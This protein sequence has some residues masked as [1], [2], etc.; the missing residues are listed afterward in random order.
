MKKTISNIQTHFSGNISESDLRDISV[1]IKAVYE[2]LYKIHGDSF[3]FN[4]MFIKIYN[5]D[6]CMKMVYKTSDSFTTITNVN[7]GFDRFTNDTTLI[8]KS[9]HFDETDGI[10]IIHL[11]SDDFKMDF[12]I[13][14]EFYH[15]VIN[16]NTSIGIISFLKSCLSYFKKTTLTIYGV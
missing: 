8:V 14:Y 6:E 9:N 2:Q 3:D 12:D 16:I 4:K 11:S 13:G 1:M 10:N 5:F 7:S 15:D